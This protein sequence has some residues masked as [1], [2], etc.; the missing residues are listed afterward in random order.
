MSSSLGCVEEIHG[1][2]FFSGLGVMSLGLIEE[3]LGVSLG[4]EI[5]AK[6]IK[7]YESNLGINAKQVDLSIE[8]S[9]SMS[10]IIESENLKPK[11]IVGCPPC[12]SFSYLHRTRGIPTEQDV[13][14]E[15]VTKYGQL[16][17]SLR[18]KIIVFENVSGVLSPNNKVYF[19]KYL[20]F[21][22]LSQY[23][24]SWGVLDAADYGVP[25]HRKRIV[26]ISIRN[27][28]KVDPTLPNPTHSRDGSGKTKKWI[29]VREAI[30]DLKPLESGD[31]DPNDPLHFAS[32]H[33]EN[34][35]KIIRAI[36]KDG[37]SRKSLPKELVLPCHRRLEKR[38]GA[39]SV[40]GRMKWD[41]PSPTITGAAIRPSSGRFVHPDQDRGITLREMARLQTIPDSFKFEGSKDSIAQMIGDAV[42][43][44]LAKAIARHV[45]FLLKEA[46]Y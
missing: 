18:P 30:G 24:T 5:D 45:R 46:G 6:R 29:T 11:V 22:K 16:A 43:L 31:T 8:T 26:A 28:L 15:L 44:E 34:T 9:K 27:D 38:K 17:A 4:L 32:A 25:Q 23:L 7:L 14:T 37:G 42:P 33:T 35:L 12:Q 1:L 21:L 36:P 20:K 39:E 3:G 2:D 41:E 19:E 13:R 40:Y 10:S